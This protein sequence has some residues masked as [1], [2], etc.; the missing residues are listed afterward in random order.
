MK[1]VWVQITNHGT[2]V[3]PFYRVWSLDPPGG[4]GPFPYNG[5]ID[6]SLIDLVNGINFTTIPDSATIIII[7]ELG[8]CES[9]LFL[10]ISTTTTTTSAP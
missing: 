6:I 1:T 9:I 2:G 5:N 10:P 7:V 4:N 3:S 8:G